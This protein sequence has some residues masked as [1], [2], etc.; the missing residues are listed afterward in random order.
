MTVSLYSA[1][2]PAFLQVLPAVLGMIG[3]AEDYC[4][5]QGLA[6]SEL[7]GAQLAPDMWDFAKQIRA[8]A[9]HSGAALEGAI[10]GELAPD[11][12][13]PPADFAGLRRMVE[14]ALAQVKAVTPEQI[15]ALTGKDT[16][17]RF[18]TRQMDFTAEDFLLSFA[19][20]NFYFHASI[21]YA[22]LR[23]KGVPLGKGDFLG[24]IRLKAPVAA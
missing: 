9:L 21:A 10:A 17:L 12:A 19:A 3:K 7:I 20:P 23:M 1:T 14:T 11:F 8:V 15:N 6:P 22:I 13:E 24:A 4:T 16:V 2:V 5:A 18:G